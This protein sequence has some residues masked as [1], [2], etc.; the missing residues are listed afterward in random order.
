MA[1]VAAA[2]GIALAASQTT[3][4]SADQVAALQTACAGEDPRACAELARRYRAGDGVARDLVKAVRAARDGC[5]AGEL[6]LYSGCTKLGDLFRMRHEAARAAAQY[7]KACAADE[8]DACTA[9]ALEKGCSSREA[10]LDFADL[11]SDHLSGYDVLS[12][13]SLA[14]APCE[15]ACAG[16]IGEA[17]DNL[18][19]MYQD[20]Y[21]VPY[22]LVQAAELRRRACQ[23]GD[24]DACDARE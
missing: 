17:C 13:A 2:L 9:L 4:R 23:L 16:G 6:A 5:E 10:C 12:E 8:K 3:A 24:R 22:D 7:R 21:G 14:R 11:C 15:I 1:A 18:A 20:G 19:D